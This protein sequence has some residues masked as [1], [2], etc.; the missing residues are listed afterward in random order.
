MVQTCP[1]CAYVRKTDET[2][3]ADTC[4]ACGIIYAKY[5]DPISRRNA[6]ILAS[7]NASSTGRRPNSL[8][9]I[10]SIVA[11]L[12][13]AALWYAT[14]HRAGNNV[15]QFSVPRV[16]GSNGTVEQREFADLF[17]HDI[18]LSSLATAGK[19]TV[20]EIYLDQCTYCRE[21]EAAFAP[22]RE[23]RSDVDIIRV[24][25]PGRLNNSISATSREELEE[26][27]A[28]MKTR[29]DSYQLCG[30]PHV[31]VFGPDKKP[32]GLDTCKHRDG[33]AFLWNWIRSETGIQRRSAPGLFS[34]M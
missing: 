8:T 31:E 4:P 22:F 30:S 29:M 1:K 27:M 18:A 12:A 13:A 25:H 5:L 16:P 20:V 32:L 21:L 14:T 3:P 9:K 23:K 11:V 34:R 24:H 19:Y 6:A 26:K 2:A 17:D 28:A 15:E 10:I 33:T 7:R